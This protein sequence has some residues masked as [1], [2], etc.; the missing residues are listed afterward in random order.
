VSRLRKELAI[1]RSK[2]K[3]LQEE[4][5]GA[6]ETSNLWSSKYDE[7]CKTLGDVRDKLHAVRDKLHAANYEISSLSSQLQHE[8]TVS[9]SLAKLVKRF[10]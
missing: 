10:I 2:S 8:Q 9:D 4:I 1:E 5:K 3:L 7:S 6:R